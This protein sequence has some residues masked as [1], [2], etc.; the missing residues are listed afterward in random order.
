M[1]VMIDL[2]VVRA[3]LPL[4]EEKLRARGMDPAVAL[5]NFAAV[6]RERRDAITQVETLKAQRNKLTEEIAKLRREGSDATAQ[7]EQTR[8]LKAEVESLEQAAAAADDR[9]REMM[10]TLPNLPQDS[11]P[12]GKDEHDNREEKVWGEKPV[13]DF[14]TSEHGYTE[15]LPPSLVNSKSL[16]GTGQLPT[17]FAE[18]LFHCDDKGPYQT[19]VY[20]EN[21]HWLIPTAEVPVTNLFRDEI[22]EEAQLPIS[23]CAY[24][25]C[26]RGEAG[27]YGKDVRGMIRQHQ[28]Q[29]VELVK[30]V[31][32]ENSAGEHERLT[33]HAETVLERL[34]LPYRRVLLCTG[35]MGFASARTYDLEVW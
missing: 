31:K 20:L 13:F 30:F 35:D 23:F 5:G 29:K 21:D 24:T 27:S 34:D 32:P 1:S 12:V 33:R 9:L 14:H 19:G 6:D 10:Q 2:A 3:N 11:V 4:V 8:T 16:F 15:V 28:F 26:F 17:K 25:P 7:T 22:L 18:D